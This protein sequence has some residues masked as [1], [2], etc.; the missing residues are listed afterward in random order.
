MNLSGLVDVIDT[1][2]NARVGRVKEAL[3]SFDTICLAA[4]GT[5][6]QRAFLT[7][8]SAVMAADLRK[9]VDLATIKKQVH[10]KFVLWTS[11]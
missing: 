6:S 10:P 7:S 1:K 4:V 8:S 5:L 2:E 11:P 3:W 9:A